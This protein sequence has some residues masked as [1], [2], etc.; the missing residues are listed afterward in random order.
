MQITLFY[1][2][3]YSHIP[4]AESD[5]NGMSENKFSEH[6]LTL[7]VHDLAVGTCPV[8]GKNTKQLP[9]RSLGKGS[10][11]II[12]RSCSSSSSYDN[13]GSVVQPVCPDK[14]IRGMA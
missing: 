4:W 7:F 3:S 5:V 9:H 2:V 10:R 11:Q 14:K 8:S 6:Y 12:E 13:K 1:C